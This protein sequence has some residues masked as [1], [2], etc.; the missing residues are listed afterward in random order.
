M[1]TTSFSSPSPA[2]NLERIGGGI[3]KLLDFLISSQLQERLFLLKIIFIFVIAG[4]VFLIIFFIAKSEYMQWLFLKGLKNFL[5]PRTLRKKM[6]VGKWKKIK[7][8]LE[9]AKIESQWK[10]ILIETL[11]FINNNLE[12]IGYKGE[13]LTEKF[14][15]LTKDDVSNLDDLLRVSK[16]CQD[17]VKDPN[18]RIEKK[19]AEEIIETFEK[20]LTELEIL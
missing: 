2:P 16:T 18:Y 11:E 6:M 5:F 1:P 17:I 14:K 13:T 15:G 9:K 7:N 20:S 12:Q 8:S 3:D 10:L 19:E 4:F